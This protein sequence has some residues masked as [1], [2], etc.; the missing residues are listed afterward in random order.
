MKRIA[1][2]PI[3]RP[4][5]KRA[6]FCTKA[7]P[8]LPN[9]D[10]RAGLFAD[11]IREENFLA[12]KSELVR[13]VE[14]GR[15]Y[16]AT[17]YIEPGEVVSIEVPMAYVHH[18]MRTKEFAPENLKDCPYF[19]LAHG[20]SFD[21]MLMSQLLPVF[22]RD[23]EAMREFFKYYCTAPTIPN[24]SAIQELPPIPAEVEE[25]YDWVPQED[26][27][28]L[29]FL[30]HLNTFCD[31]LAVK[32][33]ITA[34]A[35][36]GL[37]AYYNHSC[38]PNCMHYMAEGNLHV[39]AVK[40][41]MQ[42]QEITISYLTEGCDWMHIQD[43]AEIFAFLGFDCWCEKCDFEKKNP[44]KEW[45]IERVIQGF[46]TLHRQ[47]EQITKNLEWSKWFD[48]GEETGMFQETA[49]KKFLKPFYEMLI[50]D[51]GNPDVMKTEAILGDRVAQHVIA[52]QKKLEVF[53]S[54]QQHYHKLY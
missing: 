42:G 32:R 4:L 43:R 51:F 14:R 21:W 48:S 11:N 41:I 22:N 54:D 1:N 18:D 31:Q 19:D 9:S 5:A 26:R 17:M 13:S 27:E 15:H 35:W 40:E 52:Y 25:L 46:H 34:H 29:F 10:H 37:T 23:L 28:K 45:K 44:G 24:Y 8:E 50:T 6:S 3:V 53:A 2:W 38:D 16:L 36:Y 20:Q 47:H 33:D 12:D 39:V 30:S 49:I 7:L